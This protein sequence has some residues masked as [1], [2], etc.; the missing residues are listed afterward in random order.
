V[1]RPY[2]SGARTFEIT[3]RLNTDSSGRWER[4]HV[5]GWLGVVVKDE[6]DWY[7]AYAQDADG[8]KHETVTGTG[9]E[10]LQTAVD[11]AIARQMP[12]VCRCEPWRTV[13]GSWTVTGIAETTGS[14]ENV[15]VAGVEHVSAPT[16]D[17][18]FARACECIEAWRISHGVTT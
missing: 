1:T 6:A 15:V 12:H 2:A 3:L 4:K 14:R 5:R 11:T 17:A 10:A 18:A 7:H 16:E 8:T 9:R 13:A